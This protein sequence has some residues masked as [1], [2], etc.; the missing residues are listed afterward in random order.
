M[1]VK[2]PMSQRAR[3]SLPL[4]KGSAM[5]QRY[6]YLFPMPSSSRD[7]TKATEG[8]ILKKQNQSDATSCPGP[9][10][11]IALQTGAPEPEHQLL[12]CNTKVLLCNIPLVIYKK[13]K[14]ILFSVQ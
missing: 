4:P 11:Q 10:K 13:K 2:S 12:I 6:N 7:Y 14:N 8:V 1:V 9:L 3:G 5:A